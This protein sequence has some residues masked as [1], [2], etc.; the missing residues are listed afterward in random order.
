MAKSK[1]NRSFRE[2]Y[3]NAEY[4]DYDDNDY[5][6]KR[7]PKNGSKN[8]SKQEKVKLER[9]SKSRDKRKFDI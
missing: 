2:W 4:D 3:E 7:K 1:K 9:R 6:D 5:Q 8:L